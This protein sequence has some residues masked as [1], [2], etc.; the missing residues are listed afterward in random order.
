MILLRLELS[1]GPRDKSRACREKVYC[2]TEVGPEPWWEPEVT[3]IQVAES[4][5]RLF[6]GRFAQLYLFWVYKGL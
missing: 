5:K 1:N 2:V 3:I 6:G 4:E